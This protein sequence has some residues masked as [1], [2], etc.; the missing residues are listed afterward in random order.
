MLVNEN[1]QP[2][3]PTLAWSN[4]TSARSESARLNLAALNARVA[5]IAQNRER[6]DEIITAFDKL[7]VA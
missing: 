3:E 2:S 7:V 6:G 4:F 5:A 1:I